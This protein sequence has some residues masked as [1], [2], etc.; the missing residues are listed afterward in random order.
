MKF[1]VERFEETLSPK[2]FNAQF[3]GAQTFQK[4]GSRVKILGARSM[5]ESKFP[6]EDPKILGLTV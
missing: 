3:K 1:G 6:N 5:T 4:S 2:V